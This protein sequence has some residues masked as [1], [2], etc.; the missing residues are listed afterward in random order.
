MM[1]A[2]SEREYP[3]RPTHGHP[4]YSIALSTCPGTSS[5]IPRRVALNRR[6][7]VL[8]EMIS[9]ALRFWSVGATE[10]RKLSRA[11]PCQF[12]PGV[13]R[14]WLW[15]Q[16]GEKC[17]TRRIVHKWRPP[18]N[19]PLLCRTTRPSTTHPALNF[20]PLDRACRATRPI[21]SRRTLCAWYSS[22]S[23]HIVL[24][25]RRYTLFVRIYFHERRSDLSVF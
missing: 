14:P 10:G 6:L 12:S 7:I 19:A 16:R 8:F 13:K 22:Y 18:R 25:D 15:K 9:L 23:M 5:R 17:T 3:H 24:N 2:L 11:D 4:V 21:G 20:D 1:T